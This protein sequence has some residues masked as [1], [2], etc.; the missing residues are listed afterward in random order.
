MPTIAAIKHEWKRDQDG[1]YTLYSVPVYTPDPRRERIADHSAAELV[2]ATDAAPRPGPQGFRIKHKHWNPG[3]MNY[4]RGVNMR[5]EYG[6]AV[7]DLVKLRPLMFKEIAISDGVP[8]RS[9]EIDVE[10]GAMIALAFMGDEE[11]QID[12]PAIEVEMSAEEMAQLEIDIA[13]DSGLRLARETEEEEPMPTKDQEVT[14]ELL[15]AVRSVVIDVVQSE[16][17]KLAANKAS[18]N[19]VK[20]ESDETAENMSKTPE[21]TAEEL[22]AD[23]AKEELARTIEEAKPSDENAK[24]V[25]EL[26]ARLARVEADTF[27]KEMMSRLATAADARYYGAEQSTRLVSQSADYIMSQ[28]AGKRTEAL[29]FC[30]KQLKAQL[31]P[32]GSLPRTTTANGAPVNEDSPAYKA[33][34]RDVEV[35]HKKGYESVTLEQRLAFYEKNPGEIRL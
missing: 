4:G 5:A 13:A 16:V 14:P 35:M 31:P 3:G 27:R 11:G 28:S 22:P 15:A 19:A 32:S 25:I 12:L 18:E 9:P 21:K 33:A 29:E 23:K 26:E 10:T 6:F 1:R 8:K 7:A 2:A 34:K 30:E 24:R 20:G 17:A